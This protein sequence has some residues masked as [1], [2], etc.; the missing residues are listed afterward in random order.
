M[1]NKARIDMLHRILF[2]LIDLRE[3]NL[4]SFYPTLLPF[5]YINIKGHP[6]ALRDRHRRQL[7]QE[8]TTDVR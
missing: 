7:I 8:K 5:E 3:K 2:L 1:L 6:E 4:A